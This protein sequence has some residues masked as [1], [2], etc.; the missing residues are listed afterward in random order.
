MSVVQILTYW[1]HCCVWI[2]LLVNLQI[3]VHFQW[4]FKHFSLPSLFQPTRKSQE[5]PMDTARW[6]PCYSSS[7]RAMI[8]EAGPS[9]PGAGKNSW[10]YLLQMGLKM[11]LARL[12]KELIYCSRSAEQLGSI[13][14]HRYDPPLPPSINRTFRNMHTNS[15]EEWVSLSFPSVHFH[16]RFIYFGRLDFMYRMWCHVPLFEYRSPQG[17]ENVFKQTNKMVNKKSGIVYWLV[18]CSLIIV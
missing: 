14:K 5:N 13:S 11:L 15:G 7:K 8:H 17:Y 2:I 4:Q 6:Y 18:A 12:T 3:F 9:V 1:F 10:H 16:G